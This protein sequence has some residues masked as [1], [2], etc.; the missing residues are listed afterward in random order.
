[1]LKVDRANYCST[2]YPYHDSPCSIDY[3]ATISAPHMHAH[4][5]EELN[6]KLIEGAKVL[7]VGS[8]S[9]YLTACLAHLVGPTG[10]VYGVEHIAEL[11]TRSLENVKRDCQDLLETGRVQIIKADGRAGLEDYAPFDV[12]HVGAAAEGLPD[13]LVEQLEE[14]GRMVIPVKRDLNRQMFEC[15]DKLPGGQITRKDLLGVIYVPLTDAKAQLD[16]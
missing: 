10:R 4:A 16:K 14:G 12:I 5:L 13:K 11:V 1:M 3:N 2:K 7:D 9:G 8:G 15:I 6:D